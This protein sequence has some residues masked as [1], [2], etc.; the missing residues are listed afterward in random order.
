MSKW[1]KSGG[2]E[3]GAGEVQASALTPAEVRGALE[4][5]GLAGLSLTTL[6]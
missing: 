1:R 2:R 4:E 5:G 6:I 3:A